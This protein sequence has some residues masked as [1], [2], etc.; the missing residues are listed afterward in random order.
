MAAADVGKEADADLG[1]RKHGVFGQHPVRAME[2]NADAA[3][4]HDAVDQRDIGLRVG[5]DVGVEAIFVGEEIDGRRAAPAG[6]VDG[7]DIAAG[8]KGTSLA[9]DHDDCDGRFVA[10]RLKRL[11]E[12]LDHAVGDGVERG[13]PGQR[14]DP[15]QTDP[16]EPNLVAATKIHAPQSP[17]V[18]SLRLT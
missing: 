4:H 10:P 18:A 15:C 6:L 17:E 5:V 14:D 16:L 11:C 8:G 12:R 13:R 1:H 7:E 2:G 3:A 9:L